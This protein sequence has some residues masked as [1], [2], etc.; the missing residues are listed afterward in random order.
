MTNATHTSIVANVYLCGGTG[1]NLGKKI[2][3]I[4]NLNLVYID[5]SI[6]NLKTVNSGNIF[7]VDGMDGAG[8][9]RSVAYSNFKDISEDVLLKY[10]P[11]DVLN[12]VISSL[13]GG[14]GAV[15]APLI[16]KELVKRGCSTVVIGIDSL[17]SV[18]ERTNTANTLK[19]YR[20]IA[21]TTGKPVSMYYIENTT[22][23]E[24]DGRAIQFINLLS[25]LIDKS[26]TEEFDTADLRSFIY[27]D[28]VTDNKPT[29]A[30]LEVRPNEV[31]TAEK[32]TSI[33]GSILI[34]K[35]KES[36]IHGNYPEYLA[37]CVVSDPGYKNEDIRLN[38]LLGKLSNILDGL[39]KQTQEHQDA[40]R[41]NKIKDV[42]LSGCNDDGMAL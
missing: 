1:V 4:A 41:V 32:G 34:T 26:V 31:S 40:K 6:S 20:G 13:A 8:K 22:R 35:D 21:D 38:S 9:N 42:D 5:T 25:L 33:V 18:L 39:E 37:T 12:I 10:K 11:S 36:T 28:K 3:G 17:T 27:F 16:T 19:S 14:S 29:V 23:S 30:I 24:A 7:L 15:C 2:A